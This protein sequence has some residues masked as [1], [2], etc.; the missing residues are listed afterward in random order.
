[1]RFD[2]LGG[3]RQDGVILAYNGVCSIRFLR[4]SN[5]T[6]FYLFTY[7]DF[8]G[9]LY[10]CFRSF[11]HD[12]R[13]TFGVVSR[14]VRERLFLDLFRSDENTFYLAPQRHFAHWLG[15]GAFG[16]ALDSFLCLD[17]IFERLDWRGDIR[18]ALFLDGDHRSHH[19]STCVL[20]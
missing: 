1:M 3:L 20:H 2:E 9:G 7:L 5:E 19:E 16:S 15:G 4:Q 12:E 14:D 17:Q 13:S 11:D 18:L 8:L 6:G 10:R